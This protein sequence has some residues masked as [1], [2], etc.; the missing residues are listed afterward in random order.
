MQRNSYD[1]WDNLVSRDALY[2]NEI[3]NTAGTFAANNRN[4]EWAYD[5]D[6]RLISMNEPPFNEFPYLAPVHTYDAA[7]ST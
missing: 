6:G 7:A 2:W 1:A 3:E 5:A 4:L